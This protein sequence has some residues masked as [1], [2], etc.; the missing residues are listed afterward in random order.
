MSGDNGMSI[1]LILT[2]DHIQVEPWIWTH[3]KAIT[4]EFESAQNP[5][6]IWHIAPPIVKNVY[7]LWVMFKRIY[8]T[9]LQNHVTDVIHIIQPVKPSKGNTTHILSVEMILF[10]I[11]NGRFTL[12]Y[13]VIELHYIR[14]VGNDILLIEMS[15]NHVAWC[16]LLVPCD[17]QE[18][19]KPKLFSSN[20]EQ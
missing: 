10:Q 11:D 2:I 19:P 18:T 6:L 9:S 8:K 14:M 13:A 12:K 17:F 20:R 7:D 5:K 1:Y 16:A 3:L 4:H 15:L